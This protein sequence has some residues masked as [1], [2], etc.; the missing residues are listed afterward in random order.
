MRALLERSGGFLPTL[1]ALTLPVLFLPS[2]SD[3]YIL[4]RAATVIV[5]GCL[6]MAVALVAPAA[7]GSSLREW[8]WPLV[9]AA[10]AAVLAFAFSV[11]WPLGLAGSFT[12]YESLPMRLAYLGLAASAAWLIRTRWQ[13]DAVGAALVLGT[14][15]ACLEAFDQAAGHAPFRPD[16]NLGNA[17]LLA[18]LITLALP[19]AVDRGLRNT[20]FVGAWWGGAAV[21]AVGIW[22]TTSRS[23]G[24]GVAAG[25]LALAVLS[26][27]GRLAAAAA[28][29]S[30]AAVAALVGVIQ[31]SPLR[32]LNDDPASLRL[33]LWRD[34][35]RMIASRPL[36]GYGEDTTGIAFGR[37]L[38]HDYASLVTFDRLHSGPLDIAAAQGLLGLVALGWVLVVLARTAWRAR[39]AAGVR[40]LAAGLAGYSVWVLFNFDWA[41][42][43]GAFWLVA[44]TLWAAARM[45]ASAPPEVEPAPV[46][47]YWWRP[48]VAIALVVVATVAGV[49]PLVADYS[50]LHG[51]SDF[52]VQIDPLQ[53]Q[54]WWGVADA[55]FGDGAFRSG[56][57]ALRRAGDLGE[58]DPTLYVQLGDRLLQLGDRQAAR[59]AYQRALGIDPYF[60]P[61]RDK[62]AALGG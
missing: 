35:L 16:G 30:A 13:R 43:T 7:G 56:V 49:L 41:P 24:L 62:L 59:D 36:T 5:G 22:V 25:L 52:A 50:Y 44:G 9:A 51:R 28:L 42:A 11:S 29:A 46:S 31:L 34:G 58:T 17:N 10:A 37:F 4:P 12:R 8:R 21:M 61:A 19:I 20:N 15:I 23:G 54:Y 18:A 53:A 40:G 27:R 14:S 39:D 3:S 47:G 33:D 55:D 38:S 2:L 32:A 60:T 48:P 26:V 1:V 6:G 45:P 57:A